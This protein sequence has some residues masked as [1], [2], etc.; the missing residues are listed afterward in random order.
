[1]GFFVF[2]KECMSHAKYSKS[3]TDKAACGEAQ[4]E[5]AD[6]IAKKKA[7]YTKYRTVREEIKELLPHK[8]NIDRM[9]KK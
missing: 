8:S 3:K 4:D 1:M 9:L 5:Y 6:L 7:A 2:K